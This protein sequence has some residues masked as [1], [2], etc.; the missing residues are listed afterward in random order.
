MRI[1]GQKVN[2]DHLRKASI[3]R[4]RKSF[5]STHVWSLSDWVCALGGEAG[6]VLNLVKKIQ[7]GD[8]TTY[9]KGREVQLTSEE[10]GKEIADVVI[11]ADLLAQKLGIDLGQ[12][13]RDKFNEVSERIGSKV[14]L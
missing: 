14:E 1:A 11:Y 7:R 9:D 10:V 5:T 6:E 4:D 12:A 2:F 8:K 3:L 13:V